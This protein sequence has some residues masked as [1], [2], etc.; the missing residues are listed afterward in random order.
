[1]KSRWIWHALN[2]H[3]FVTVTRS[4]GHMRPIS[5]CQMRI[6]KSIGFEIKWINRSMRYHSDCSGDLVGKIEGV[7]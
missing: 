1:M 6:F 2:G 3:Y 4:L 5:E 7:S